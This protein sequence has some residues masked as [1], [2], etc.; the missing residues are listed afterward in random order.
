MTVAP[1]NPPP[2]SSPPASE[3]HTPV[4]L[5]APSPSPTVGG[6]P[7]PNQKLPRAVQVLQ[8]FNK[9]GKY[10]SKPLTPSPESGPR[11]SGRLAS[12]NTALMDF[13]TKCSWCGQFGHL[14][15]QCP[16]V[17]TGP[18]AAAASSNDPDT[19]TWDE[20]M[21]D[22]HREEW[23]AAA[24]TEISALEAHGT[25]E[26]V[27]ISDAK[28]KILPG[29]WA[30]KVKRR[31]DGSIIKRKMRYCVRGDLQEGDVD[32][33]SQVAA[34]SS[35]R[36]LLVLSLTLDWYTC[37]C[38]F[39]N[40]F[41]Q[42][43]LP[44]PIW[45]HL[46]RGFQ[47][48]NNS[49][50]RTI[51]RLKKS[52]YGISEAPK[53]WQEHLA[54]ALMGPDLQLKRSPHDRCV[55]YKDGAILVT[56]V[57]DILMV[58]RTKSIADAIFAKL[59][60]LGFSFTV[61]ES[62]TSYLGIK[63]EHDSAEGSFNMTQPG[64][65]DKIVEAVGMGDCNPNKTPAAKAALS[66]DEDGP[67]FQGP[68]NYR[69]VVGMLIYLSTNTRPD[70]AFAVS[71]VA[72]FAHAPRETHA[73]AV[74]TIIRYLKGSR[75]QGTIVKPTGLL[76]LEAFC[77]ADFAG[78]FGVET[79]DDPSSVKSRMGYIIKLGGCP[80]IWKSQLIS[81]IT[82]STAES[83]YAALS[84][85]MR[86]LIPLRRLLLEV[87]HG[88]GLPQPQLASISSRVFEDNNAALQLAVNQR[89]TNRTRH[90][91]VKWHH[92][93][94]HVKPTDGGDPEIQVLRV[95]TQLQDA[96]Y[97]TKALSRETFEANRLRV[98]GW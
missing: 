60:E 68:W 25:W 56:W 12:V 85:C 44:E 10:Y 38:D 59:K 53:L 73:K 93:W 4:K 27:P 31:P 6:P 82:L 14:K 29:T 11:R 67:L 94:S 21:A 39:S 13:D 69:S 77:D 88:L 79:P 26:E 37:C 74:K 96:D 76:A 65:V 1:P 49:K 20:C 40:A 64:L 42:A 3:S 41:V 52:L 91:L 23:I 48:N 81:E 71:Q 22:E 47:A 35:V 30:G 36:L 16:T 66:K 46:P 86:V 84:A 43:I 54:T 75:D 63:F 97:L 58:V 80:I 33:H 51:L 2:P 87:A 28:A 90:Y 8:D 24:Q 18:I 7:S 55:F 89:I 62:V 17:W 72:R 9:A 19:L 70:I 50:A 57:D 83:E 98:Q 78:L 34:W 61:E 45:I 92:F 95:E 15:S 32:S 5:E